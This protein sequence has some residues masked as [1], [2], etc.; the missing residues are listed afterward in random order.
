MNLVTSPSIPTD[1]KGKRNIGQGVV[2][3]STTSSSIKKPKLF[4]D[5]FL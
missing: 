1:A 5:A 4:K 3:T 2:M